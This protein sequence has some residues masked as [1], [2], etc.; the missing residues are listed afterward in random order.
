MVLIGVVRHVTMV[1]NLG[2]L[3]CSTLKYF[4]D[5][6]ATKGGKEAPKQSTGVKKLT[7]RKC[8]G[9]ANKDRGCDKNPTK[10]NNDNPKLLVTNETYNHNRISKEIT[11]AHL[12]K[13]NIKQKKVYHAEQNM[14]YADNSYFQLDLWVTDAQLRKTSTNISVTRFFHSSLTLTF[15]IHYMAKYHP[16]AWKVLLPS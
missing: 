1:V 8:G 4:L 6:A 9:M 15:C 2:A 3:K 14:A 16:L 5:K 13:A 7:Q 11:H 10:K 12:L